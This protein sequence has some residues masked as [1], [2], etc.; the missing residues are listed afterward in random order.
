MLDGVGDLAAFQ[1]DLRVE[2]VGGRGLLPAGANLGDDGRGVIQAVPVDLEAGQL[3][4]GG[5]TVGPVGNAVE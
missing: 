2:H 1:G 3:Y 4:Q 5:G